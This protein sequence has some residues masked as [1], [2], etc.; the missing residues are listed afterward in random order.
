MKEGTLESIFQIWKVFYYLVWYAQIQ[1]PVFR[2]YTDRYRY[3]YQSIVNVFAVRLSC[4]CLFAE[5]TDFPPTTCCTLRNTS[6]LGIVKLQIQKAS[7]AAFTSSRAVCTCLNTL[8][9]IGRLKLL[10]SW[11][12]FPYIDKKTHLKW[13]QRVQNTKPRTRTQPW[14]G[15]IKPKLVLPTTKPHPFSEVH[16]APKS[17]RLP[18]KERKTRTSAHSFLKPLTCFHTF[19]RLHNKNDCNIAS[20]GKAKISRAHTY[21]YKR[22]GTGRV[23]RRQCEC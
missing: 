1:E 16:S 23:A 17:H 19:T 4:F 14:I 15:K 18:S 22:Q 7:C 12:D 20:K 9:W 3:Q 21:K 5:N 8:F 13:I 11:P 6:E 10:A 2:Y